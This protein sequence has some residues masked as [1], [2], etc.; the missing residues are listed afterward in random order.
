MRDFFSSQKTT[1][2]S[3]LF[4]LATV[5]AVIA[6][7]SS[8]SSSSSSTPTTTPTT[9]IA[10]VASL[11]ISGTPTT[12]FSDN[13]NSTTITVNAI[14]ASN[15]SIAGATIT[16]SSSSGQLSSSTLVTD[17][18]G[19][20][21]AT[22][23]SGLGFANQANRTATITATSGTATALLPV[24][25]T[26]STLALSASSTSLSSSGTPPATLTITAKDKGGNPISGTTVTLT[27]S[28]TGTVILTP[29]TGTTNASGQL[30]VT[31]AGA[32]AGTVT[33]SATAAGVTAT[34]NFTVAA[35]GSTFGISLVTL[36]AGTGVVPVSPKTSS[37][38]IGDTLAVQVTA[39]SPTTTVLFA[40]DIGIWSGATVGTKVFAASGVMEITTV[41]GIATATLQSPIAGVARVQVLD[42]NSVVLSDT[43]SVGITAKIADHITLQASPTV[44]PQS[45]GST[46]GI[47][48]LTA[49][50]Y[51]VNNQAVGDAPVA[52]SIV[53]GG[54]GSGEIVSPVVVFSAATTAGGLALGAAP[55]SFTSGSLSSGAS[56]VQVRASVV[57]T[58]IATQSIIPVSGVPAT[59]S[60]FDAAIVIGGTAGSVAFGLATKITDAGGTSTIYSFPMSVLVADSNGNPA[61]KGTVVN[62]STWPI[63]WSTG[64]PC[65]VDLD[66]GY[67]D[68]AV[69]PVWHAANIGTF[70]NEDVNEN[71]FLDA[72]EDGT[73]KFF[74]S[75]TSTVTTSGGSTTVSTGTKDGQLTPL[76]SWGGT[77]VSTNPL[78]LPGTA[79]TDA[80]GLATFN[81]TY[82]KSSA[83]WI[84]DRI[85]ARTVVQGSPAV[86]Q[87]DWRLEPSAAD[88]SPPSTCF[89]PPSPFNF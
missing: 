18:T 39:P 1:R 9:T 16:L 45:I 50:V 22:L 54:T 34:I 74:S 40:T 8:G 31:V 85:R 47:S 23:S 71:L 57:G 32:T 80:T 48:N 43:L 70:L 87:L 2:F 58:A 56:G 51:D 62:I 83:L 5:I 82:T 66:G 61:P 65:N 24:Q 33:V 12:I 14:N 35:S 76:N 86:G 77:I 44:L 6:G 21:T 27:Q 19:K 29:T 79:T 89:L 7:C 64:S 41:G 63:A 69:P 15:A 37:M 25:I 67:W 10:P 13:S 38:R 81:L 26:G 4:L 20:A 72:G 3:A 11:Q 60:S 68:S 46:V 75:G 78:D 73:R 42:P 36:N 55:T 17:A 49:T 84:I 30:A 53:N 52:F 28:S 88:D 59:T